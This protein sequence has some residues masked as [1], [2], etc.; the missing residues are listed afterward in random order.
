MDHQAT[1]LL[2]VFLQAI[3]ELEVLMANFVLQLGV[4]NDPIGLL[5][6]QP[7]TLEMIVQ[8]SE[9]LPYTTNSGLSVRHLADCLL[10]NS[11]N[12]V[13]LPIYDIVHNEIQVDFRFL[14]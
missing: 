2:Q 1:A 10:E 4:L 13:Y 8:E 9:H 3:F 12:I 5:A 14:L 6:L 7:R 11:E